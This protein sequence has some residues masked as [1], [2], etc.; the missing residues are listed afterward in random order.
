MIINGLEYQIKIRSTL[1]KKCVH[2]SELIYQTWCNINLKCKIF[3]FCT[4]LFITLLMTYFYC[5][6]RYF[7]YSADNFIIVLI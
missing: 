7:T 3:K 5:N 1:F 4:L 6:F 2:F